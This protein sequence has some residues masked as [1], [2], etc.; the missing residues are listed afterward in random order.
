M[1]LRAVAL[2]DEN[3]LNKHIDAV[4]CTMSLL[5]IE[6]GFDEVFIVLFLELFQNYKFQSLI[7][8]FRL[9]LALQQLALDSK[10]NFSDAKR[11]CIHNMVA[12]YL[13][14]SAQLIA[15][16]SLCQQ[17][18]HVVSCRAQRGIPGLNL[19]LNVKDS[20]N[21]DDPLSSSALNSTSQGA[22]TIT[23][24]D[25]TLL[26]NAEDIAESLKASGK[27]ATR[28]FVPFNFNMNGRKND[29]SGDQWQNDTPNFDS[30]DGRESPSGYKTVGIDDVSVD[31]SVD[32]T[33][34]VSRKQSRRNT[35]FSIVNPPSKFL[36][37][38]DYIL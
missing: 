16:P 23:E 9:S 7:E 19:L 37:Y 2:A 36:N 26:F 6:V 34:P 17:V 28:L 21:N 25:Q 22:T 5:C 11:N 14:L 29:G 4:L 33:P 3:D 35:I 18:Q 31:M 24:E 27:D 38:T 13:N 10:Q 15:N 30:T 32:W 12:K 1:L 20:P 8:L